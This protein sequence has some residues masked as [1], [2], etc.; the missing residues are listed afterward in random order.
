MEREAMSEESEESEEIVRR[1]VA[2]REKI[3]RSGQK[4]SETGTELQPE[5]ERDGER[6]RYIDRREMRSEER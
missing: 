3:V 6:D 2:L 1:G 4:R 5:K